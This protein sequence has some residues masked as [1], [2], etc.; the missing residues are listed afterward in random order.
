MASSNANLPREPQEF[1]ASTLLWLL[2]IGLASAAGVLYFLD[3]YLG[4][5]SMLPIAFGA[6]M[7]F[8]SGA[9]KM[10]S[11][12]LASVFG[13]FLAV[14]ASKFLSPIIQSAFSR[15]ISDSSLGLGLSGLVVG[16]CI[17][18]ISILIG[19]LLT[20]RYPRFRALD[21]SLG[22]LVGTV[23]SLALIV[24]GLWTILAM[25]PRMLKMR[26]SS[27]QSEYESSSLFHRILTISQATRNSPYLGHLVAW[28]PIA[29]N[30]T[31]D[32]LLNKTETMVRDVRSKYSE[33]PAEALPRSFKLT[34]LLDDRQFQGSI[35][36]LDEWRRQATSSSESLSIDSVGALLQQLIDGQRSSPK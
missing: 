36:G 34:G 3:D 33:A 25:E 8:R 10:F 7:G 20:R 32:D 18:A 19:S 27:A 12:L 1:G 11:M 22:M 30:A 26:A 31:L 9:W 15:P 24:I 14:P 2:L 21:Q 16:T 6:A 17:A 23:K 28:N 35:D 29:T 5:I 4:A 13:F